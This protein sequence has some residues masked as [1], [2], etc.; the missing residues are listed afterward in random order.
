MGDNRT[1]QMGPT[2]ALFSNSE[3]APQQSKRDDVW[4]K[5]MDELFNNK[6]IYHKGD[7]SKRMTFLLARLK[8]IE[9]KTGSQVSK[10]FAEWILKYSVSKDRKGRKEY[11]QMMQNIEPEESE[12]QGYLRKVLGL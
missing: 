11:V 5:T 9:N 1:K 6:N 10:Q 7:I 2:D 4:E 8:I 12:D 3:Q